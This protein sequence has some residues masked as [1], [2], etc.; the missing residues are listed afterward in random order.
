M[1]V[2]AAYRAERCRMSQPPSAEN[3]APLSGL[4]PEAYDDLRRLAH[5]QIRR[6]GG[7]PTLSTTALVH[8]A[9][10]KLAPSSGIFKDRG[11]FLALAARAMRQVIVD[12]ARERQAGKRG[13][14]QPALPLDPEHAAAD[15]Q[16]ERI[17]VLS[18]ALG[19]LSAVDERA[20]RVVECRFF[21]G[22]S[23]EETAEALAV[24]ART[25]ERDWVKAREWLR[26]ALQA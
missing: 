14:G 9:Y 21:A 26:E 12:Y 2:C 23:E 8:E 22:Y 5:R 16:A 11:H 20:A 17:L 25:V 19:R 7:T 6:F 18:D 4:L 15:L 13:G 24:S 10:L 3:D 1:H